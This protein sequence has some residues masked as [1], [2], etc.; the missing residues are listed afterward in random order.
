VS[1]RLLKIRFAQKKP[2]KPNLICYISKFTFFSV[3]Y[4]ELVCSMYCV[5]LGCVVGSNNCC[6]KSGWLAAIYKMSQ[7]ITVMQ[8][9]NTL[10]PEVN[11]LNIH[12]DC[13]FYSSISLRHHHSC[14]S[15]HVCV[16]FLG[17][18]RNASFTPVNPLLIHKYF[19][20]IALKV[21]T[22]KV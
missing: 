17:Y 6:I 21:H 9:A 2:A 20:I 18:F 16:T 5:F 15:L 12:N 22:V 7:N 4:D 1:F 11:S 10:I 8:K 19:C 3:N 14:T 13:Y